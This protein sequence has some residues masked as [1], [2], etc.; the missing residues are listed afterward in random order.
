M[1]ML[2]GEAA[3]SGAAGRETFGRRSGGVGDPRRAPATPYAALRVCHARD[4]RAT[5]AT[6]ERRGRRPAPSARDPRRARETRAERERPAPSAR[7]PRR[8][9]ETRAERERPAPSA[10][11]PRRARETRAER[12]RPAPSARDPR[13]A[14]ETRAERE[15]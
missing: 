7:D 1:A 12:E 14:R 8:A 2:R 3:R 11:D 13:R 6:P 9:R 15:R 5:P 4:G 10:R